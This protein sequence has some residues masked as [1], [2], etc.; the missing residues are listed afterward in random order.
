M[1][2]MTYLKAQQWAFSFIKKEDSETKTAIELLLT[3]QM[4][5]TTT[6]LLLHLR[7]EMKE[8]DF[9]QFKDNVVLYQKGWPVQY[10][11]GET[12]FYGLPFNVT[13]DTLIPRMETEELIEWILKDFPQNNPQRILDIGAGTGAIGLTLKSYRKNWDVTLS[14]ISSAVLKVA[15]ENAKNLNLKV[16]LIQSDLFE[17]INTKFDVI[18]SNPPYISENEVQYMD[19]SVLEHEP[20]QA[21][22]AANDGLEI[23]Q[24]IAQTC[25]QYLNN[26]AVMYLEIGFKQGKMVQEIFQKKFIHAKIDLKKDINGHDRM[27]RIKF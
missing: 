27:V 11:L 9:D 14:D 13:K 24:R 3:G 12:Q 18:V 7:D 1:N 17:Q 21:L 15:N 10:I 25:E 22:F 20:Y 5:W 2:K 19:Q 4:K 23:Y 16:D 26:N 6:D 8:K